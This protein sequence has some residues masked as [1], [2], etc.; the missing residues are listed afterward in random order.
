M[1]ALAIITANAQCVTNVNFNTWM[2]AGNP[3]N[4]SWNIQNGGSQIYQTANGGDTYF[5]SPYDLM[6]VD[7]TGRFK[8]DDGAPFSFA[9]DDDWMGFVFSF[10][11][12]MSTGNYYDMWLYDWKQKQ[13]GASP[14]GM[15]LDRAY[16]TITNTGAA[17]DDHISSPEFTVVQNTFGGPGWQWDHWHYLELKLT[18]TRAQIYIDGALIFDHVDCYK[19]GRFGFYNR[20]QP[21]CYYD[22]FQYTAYVDY[23][24]PPGGKVC[25]GTDVEF[26]FINPCVVVLTNYQSLTYHFGDGTP[27]LVI[28][29][30]TVANANAHHTY[31]TNGTYT[32]S[33]T[34]VD[35]NGCSATATHN[36]TV[37]GP[38]HAN[39]TVTEP[40]CN[41]ATNGNITL[42]PT[43]GFGNY[44]YTWSGNSSNVTNS[45]IGLTAGTYNVTITDGSCNKDTSITLNQPTA[46]TAVTSHTDAHCG[47][48]DGTAT[49]TVSGGTPPYTGI[50]WAGIATTNGV[51]VTGLAP[52]TQ[53]ADFHDAQGCS[54]LLQYRETIVS[55]PCGVTPTVTKTNV[56]CFGVNN[57]SATLN[58]AGGTPPY[59]IT[60]SNSVVSTSLPATINNLAPGTYTYNYTD[61]NAAHAFTG[62][63]TIT[64]PGAGMVVNLTTVGITCPGSNDGQ[65]IASVTSGGNSPYTYTWSGGQPSTPSLSN[66]APG[67]ISVTITDNTGCSASASG[68]ISSL[69]SLTATFNTVMDSCYYSGKGKAVVEV[70]G[71][72]QPYSYV[73]SNFYTDTANAN[74]VAGTYTVTVT[75]SRNC[76]VTGSATVTGGPAFSATYVKQDIGCKGTTTGSFT[77]TPSGGTPGYNYAWSD[78]SATGANPTNL[79]AGPYY[80]TVTDL[81][82][83]TLSNG[84]T[85]REPDSLLVAT[86][87][88]TNVTCPGASDGSLTI[89]VGGGTPPYFY[90]GN[91][92]PPGSTTLP[93]IPAG[94]Y[95]GNLI[96]ANNCSIPLSE[97]VTEPA[98]QSLSLTVTDITC[99]G[100][101]NGTATANFVNGT[102]T[103]TYNWNPGGAQPASRTGLAAGTYNVTG[104]DANGC[105][106]TNSGTINEPPAQ[107]MPVTATDAPCYGSNG[108]ATANPAG[109]APYNYTW[110]SNGSNNATITPPAGSYT[111]TAVDAN[112]CNF[113]GSF[114]INQ[115]PQIFITEVH[116]DVKCYGDATGDIQVTPSGG[117]GTPYNYAWTP[118]SI[119]GSTAG[120]LAAGVYTV[121]VTD[122][123]NC[124]A[125]SAITIAQPT[126]ALTV[127]TQSQ[128]V[129][130]FGQTNGSITLT[131]TGGTGA[132]SYTWNPNVSTT[133][134]A[135]NLAAGTYNI[136][137]SDA[138]NCSVITSVSITSPASALQINP[139]QVDLTCNGINTGQITLNAAGGTTPYVYNWNPAGTGTTDAVTGLAAGNYS[140]T[141]LDDNTCSVTSTFTITQPAALTVS[142]THSNEACAGDATAVIALTATGGTPAYT[143]AWSGGISTTDSAT[144]LAAG[145]YA[146]TITDANTCTVS[147]STTVTEP[148][149]INLTLTETDVLC[150]GEAN[151]TITA[152]ATGGVTP[153]G[154]TATDGTNALN[155]GSGQFNNLT[156]ATY[157]VVVTDNNTCT[158]SNTITVNEPQGLNTTVNVT[159][160]TCYGY[161][162]GVITI[163]ATGGPSAV[164]TYG[165]ETGASNAN[166]TFTGLTA[167]M[168]TY[169]ITDANSCTITDSVEVMQPDSATITVIPDSS[170]VPLGS[171]IDLQA[172]TNMTSP[173]TYLWQPV[174]GL[175]CYDCENPT[176]SGNYTT[177]YTVVATNGDGCTAA[178]EIV[179]RVVPSYDIFVPNAFTPNGDGMNDLWQVFGNLSTLKQLTVKVYNRI[180]EK[181]FESTDVH[182][183]WDGNYKGVQSPV[184][185][186]T[187]TINFV[188]LD[189]H[190]DSDYKGTVT[191][192]R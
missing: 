184:G 129:L 101:A 40:T 51:P 133:N 187:Y 10:I 59:N 20:S 75:D 157:T 171:E 167:D 94:V 165:L 139:T 8:T 179:V 24:L 162:N 145:A 84:D 47:V 180:G 173:I 37:A 141:V 82:G 178:Q 45:N 46:L 107:N 89:T 186:Y 4:G 142:Q 55:L 25:N 132:Y 97:T 33:I 53:I 13:Q 56:T 166:G 130:C 160:A 91:P 168:Y 68:T 109:T 177:H 169:T 30:P 19:P 191:L 114:T 175:S 150:N 39:P 159:D 140:V 147:G 83:C 29:N 151:G 154:F 35:N 99:N 127:N 163:L 115:G 158:T 117:A 77:V 134:T 36:I 14:S 85:I 5:V 190:S 156:A 41:G 122:A 155:S 44:S 164:Y 119:T 100:A 125:D 6:N 12:P 95:S 181:V 42:N 176:F 38:I 92:V 93:N 66:L 67:N 2:Q 69:P 174:D 152:V 48:N 136:T 126:T 80:F 185:V 153:Y 49:I 113:T 192:L 148:A 105:T 18:Y 57:G 79:A 50:S 78:P 143:Y 21:H 123:N 27:D 103:V 74:L 183:G 58:V 7:V 121:T 104:T 98:A 1:F 110:S 15:S 111:V 88:H 9:S 63:V 3:S 54:A 43:N 161:S 64:G 11:Q 26:Q 144:N 106:V 108:S 135:S 86:S 72:T 76:S 71:G 90:Q 34:A 22:N 32:T 124:S 96:D 112:M 188:W 102:G 137:I 65:A 138:N 17:F 62:N 23:G 182:F 189:N 170:N 28:T 16:G 116:T 81:Y 120:S 73:W 131:A 172:T 61:G 149:P 128:G 146:Y 118:S 60:W 70:T 52:G 31:T 87:S